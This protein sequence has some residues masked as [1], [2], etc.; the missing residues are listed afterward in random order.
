LNTCRNGR[1][2]IYQA[3]FILILGILEVCFVNHVYGLDP[4]R[5]LSQYTHDYWGPAQ[6]FASGPVYAIAQTKD[7]YLWLGTEK[8]LFRFDGSRF[9]LFQI[10]KKNTSQPESVAGLEI[11]AEGSLWVRMRSPK[12]FRYRDGKFEDVFAGSKEGNY[13]ITAM[14]RGHS[15]DIL[16]SKFDRGVFRYG[17]ADPLNL[18]D[19]IE[20]PPSIII[21]LAETETGVIWMGTGEGLFRFGEERSWI[22]ASNGLRNRKINFILPDGK[23]NLWIGTDSGIAFWDGARFIEPE[24]AAGV[25]N[26]RVLKILKDKQSNLWVA[27]ESDGLFRL[28]QNGEASTKAFDFPSSKTVTALFEDREGNLWIGTPFGV[29]R[30]RDNAFTSYSTAQGLPPVSSGGALY[31]DSEGKTWFSPPEG[32]LYCLKGNSIESVK[33]DGIE[34]DVVYSIAG[35]SGK[36]ELWLGRQHGGLTRLYSDGKSYSAETFI[37][38]N[39]L[40][41][42]SV[43]TVFQS[44]DKSVWAGTL[45][46]GVSRFKDGVFTTYTSSD[47]GGLSSNTINA[48]AESEN[49][50]MWFGTPRGLSSLTNGEWKTY[51]SKDGLP[52]DKVTTLYTDKNGVLWIGTTKGLSFLESGRV[53]FIRNLPLNLRETVFGIAADELGSLWIE[54]STHVLRVDKAKLLSESNLRAEDVREFSPNDGLLSVEGIKRDRSVVSDPQGRIWFSLHQGISLVDPKRLKENSVS[55]LVH[56][57]QVSADGTPVGSPTSARIPAGSRRIVIN[58]VGLSLAT[59]NRVRYRYQLEDFDG[60]WSEP[61]NVGEASY[62]NLPPGT[63]RFRV[64]A[65]NADGAWNSDE[66]MIEINVEPMYWQ[67]WWF[68]ILCFLGAILALLGLYQYRLRRLA[69]ELNFRF[70]ERLAERTRIAQELHDTL[71]QGVFS[72]SVQLDAVVKQVPDTANFKPRLRRVNELTKQI[73]TEGR[74]TIK[75]M[76][77]QNSENSLVLEQA[78]ATIRQDLDV[79]EAIDFRVILDGIPQPLRPIVRDEIYRIGREALVNAFKHSKADAIEVQIEYAPKYFRL[80]VRDN[81]CGVNAEILQKGR[82]GHLGLSGMRIGAE[83]LGAKVKIWNRAEG[84]TEIELI[85]PQHIAFERKASDGGWF[86]RRLKNLRA[87]KSKLQLSKREENQ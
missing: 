39:G 70:D 46:G 33:V 76:R 8:G 87:S 13:R 29:E 61:T 3:V 73:M 37:Q 21:S 62:T 85:V 34:K 23:E 38:K 28:N 31:V 7:G 52:S 16:L 10:D 69:K 36:G 40:A 2:K 19:R 11:D 14:S 9:V 83:K 5:M 24:W 82:K 81:G 45:T 55:T 25:K 57:D 44:S 63:Y 54:T 18:L 41:Q 79:S 49:G 35:A 50:A 32:G 6:G 20:L 64:I 42:D 65:S 84:G 58:Y 22:P 4:E 80:S 27:T 71:L 47:T 48:I 56:I 66:A 75:G 26:S 72:A 12:V 78:F 17:K 30:L 67:T 15:G 51:L 60:N 43:F 59:P 77:S 53:H 86:K 1:A 74:N 68:Q